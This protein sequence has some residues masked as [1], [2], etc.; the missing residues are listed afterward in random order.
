MKNEKDLSVYEAP[1]TRVVELVLEQSI[2]TSSGDDPI[3]TNP[4]MGWDD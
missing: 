4:D 1:Q 2:L 3:V